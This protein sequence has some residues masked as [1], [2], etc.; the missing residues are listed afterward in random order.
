MFYQSSYM[1]D[2][3]R[4]VGSHGLTLNVVFFHV[5]VGSDVGLRTAI[6]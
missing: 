6:I 1:K 2:H 3:G 4:E 5:V